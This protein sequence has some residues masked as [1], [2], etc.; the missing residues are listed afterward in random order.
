M[1]FKDYCYYNI[2][3]PE[4]FEEIKN[5]KIKVKYAVLCLKY[6]IECD[7]FMLDEDY[8]VDVKGINSVIDNELCPYGHYGEVSLSDISK[9]L[10][11]KESYEYIEKE[12]NIEKLFTYN[13]FKKYNLLNFDLLEKEYC[14]SIYNDKS[15]FNYSLNNIY[16][17]YKEYIYILIKYY[18]IKKII[19]HFI[20]RL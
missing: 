6:T 4:F 10:Y 13:Y 14:F 11:E 2:I 20:R 15:D 17:N 3:I 8:N 19:K 5:K 9:F 1:K 7:E 16:N 18:D 12:I